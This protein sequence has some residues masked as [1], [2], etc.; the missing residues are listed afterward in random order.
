MSRYLVT[1]VSGFVGRYFCRLL[2]DRET[3]L[4]IM[5][6]DLGVMMPC[7]GHG[8]EYR[9]INLLA[10]PEAILEVVAEFQPDYVL[11]LAAISSVSQS[12]KSPAACL[13]G[14]IGIYANLLEAVRQKSPDARVLSVG[15]SEVY[16]DQPEKMMPLKETVSLRPNNP[17]GISRVAQENLSC[18][19]RESYGLQIMTTRSFNHI[20]PGQKEQFVIPSFVSQLVRIAES[21]KSGE[22]KAGNIDLIRDF[23]D[24]RDVVDA[25]WRILKQ[26]RNG[27]VYNVCSGKGTKL[28]EIINA[29]AEILKIEV[30]T[31][32]DETRVRQQDSKC[33]IGDNSRIKQ[34][35]E[36]RPQYT[37]PR[38]LED[39]VS[40]RIVKKC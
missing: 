10:E 23:S 27:E 18:L 5:G 7:P 8:F 3:D 36:W 17:Y 38:T 31:R 14:N 12:W 19:Y 9:Q 39:M 29:I 20:G 1:G 16:G 25:Y 28:K 6:V 26:G 11:N 40:Y 24:V 35:L 13:A 22:I 33:V 34:S 30:I 4:H 15:S 2:K 21:G 32:T 37:L